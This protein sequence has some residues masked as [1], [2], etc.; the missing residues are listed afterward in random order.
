[1]PMPKITASEPAPPA[2]RFTAVNCADP[3]KTSA[4]MPTIC[5]GLRPAARAVTAYTM[6][7]S[8]APGQNGTVARTPAHQRRRGGVGVFV[9]DRSM[10]V[11]IIAPSFVAIALTVKEAIDG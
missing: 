6:A 9:S 3:E 10:V 8:A 4:D 2:I 11:S 5:A 1:M 7:K